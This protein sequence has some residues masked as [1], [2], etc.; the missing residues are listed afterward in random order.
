VIDGLD[1]TRRSRPDPIGPP[2]GLDARYL[3]HLREAAIDWAIES[4]EATDPVARRA[5]IVF[6]RNVLTLIDEVQRL[7]AALTPCED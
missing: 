1:L 5:A 2:I 6:A 3:D 7:R 4:V